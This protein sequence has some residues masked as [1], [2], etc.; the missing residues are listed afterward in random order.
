MLK[1]LWSK[2][3]AFY[4]LLAEYDGQGFIGFDAG[5]LDVL[6]FESFHAEDE[7]QAVDGELEVGLGGGVVLLFEQV[8]VIVDLVSVELSRQAVEMQGQ[9]GQVAGVVLQCAL[10]P[11]GDGDFLL[12]LLV[13]LA[14]SCYISTGSLDEGLLFFFIFILAL[15]VNQ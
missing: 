11:A 3:Q 1:Q 15:N 14:E 10:A 2:E 9:L 4:F 13:K 12:E 5:Q 7:A 8:E 6:V